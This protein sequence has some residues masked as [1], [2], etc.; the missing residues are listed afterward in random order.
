VT[1]MSNKT[2]SH[3]VA[4]QR[5]TDVTTHGAAAPLAEA[6]GADRSNGSEILP[7]RIAIPQAA[8]DDLKERLANTRWLDE[9][10]GVGWSR[11]VPAKYLKK[12]ADYW[13]GEY[14]WRDHETRLNAYPQFTTR[15]DGQTVHFL[16]VRSPEPDATPLMLIHGWPGSVVEFLDVIGPLSDP[17]AHGGDSVD[18]FHLVIPSIPGH[19]FSRP[20]SAAGWT[21]H[22]IAQ[23]FTELMSRLG[24]QRYGVQGGDQGAFIAPEMGR[25][26]PAH[27][28]GVHVNSLVQIPTVSQIMVG[29]VLMS[30]AERVRLKRFK[31]FN[32][33]MRGYD[34][35]QS[36]RPKTLAYGLTDSPV[37][38]LAWIVEKFKEWVDPAAALPEDAISRDHILT[39]ISLYWFSGT[40]GSSANLYYETLHDPAAKKRKLRNKVPTGVYVSLTQDVTIRRWA[41]RE[42]NIVRWTE[43]DHG[44]HFAALERPGSFARDVSEFFHSLK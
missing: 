31:H 36:T 37:G 33:E 4:H 9:S 23:A 32:D 5:D 30:K 39:N 28:V 25:I 42:N 38:Q 24:Y 15:I 35:I 2:R 1:D 22:R 41:E 3:H 8:I 13:Q 21:S 6:A 34:H 29:L 40:A 10:P 26:D 18:A 19:G 27:I 20:L 12:L 7:F 43:F 14:D 44:G 16:H 17:R 11:G